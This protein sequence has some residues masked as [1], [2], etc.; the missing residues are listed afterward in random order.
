MNDER[1]TLREGKC[2]VD[3]TPIEDGVAKVEGGNVYLRGTLVS[4][5]GFTWAEAGEIGP[6]GNTQVGPYDLEIIYD[7]LTDHTTRGYE[8]LSKASGIADKNAE[9][10]FLRV[11]L[12]M[13][14][15]DALAR[16]VSEELKR[17]VR[18]RRGDNGRRR[19]RTDHAA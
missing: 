19:R 3:L 9:W 2:E 18:H 13:D 4:A 11:E 12:A 5:P 7:A 14:D 16:A 6:D 15:Q 1:T 10:E 8:N 17:P